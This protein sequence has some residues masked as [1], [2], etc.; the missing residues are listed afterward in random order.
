MLKN[1]YIL[2]LEDDSLELLKFKLALSQLEI[3]L[4]VQSFGNGLLGLEF[5]EANIN[6]LPKVIVLD[7]KMPVMSG[8]EFLERIK[9]HISLRR[10]PVIVLSSSDND[11]DILYSFDHQVAGYFV[12]PFDTDEYHQIV[13]QIATYWQTSKTSK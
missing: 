5:L 6:K 12:K 3:A 9:A 11:N 1:D 13:K 8:I 7:L 4:P 10:V 2:Y